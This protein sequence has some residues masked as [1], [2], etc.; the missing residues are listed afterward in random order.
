LG[1]RTRR[2]KFILQGWPYVDYETLAKAYK[3]VVDPNVLTIGRLS[4]KEYDSL[5]SRS[6]VFV[7]LF[8][9]A[10]C[11]TIIECIVRATPVLTNRL[12]ASEEYLGRGYPMFYE[13]L[14]EAGQMADDIE[15]I[16]RAHEYLKV[17]N[18]EQFTM[19]YFINSL[20][21]SEIYQS[22]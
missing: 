11:N 20:Y 22:I 13:T 16:G 15:T 5:L 17:M 19:K 3:L 7:P 21:R 1:R 2:A 6:L 14:E 12:P 4:D 8:D 18:K 10:A 9:V